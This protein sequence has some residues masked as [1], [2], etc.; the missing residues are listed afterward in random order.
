MCGRYTLFTPQEAIAE[1]VGAVR[2]APAPA[3]WD[4]PRYNIA[5]TQPVPIVRLSREGEL[6]LEWV[7]WGLVPFFR[8]SIKDGPLLINARAET[9]ATTAAFREA[10]AHRRCLVPANGFFE[11]KAAATKPPARSPRPKKQ[12]YFIH[13]VREELVL[14]AGLWER[15]RPPPTSA[16]PESPADAEPPLQSCAIITTAANAA[17]APLHDRMP[18]VLTVDAARD[19]LNPNA[20]PDVLSSLLA[21]APKDL[22]AVH[23][24]STEVNRAQQEG[25]QLIEPVTPPADHASQLD[26]F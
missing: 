17:V 15:W 3:P 13:P 6:I 25:P 26:L 8:K 18:A 20:H 7:R 24:V 22:M 23:P 19:W 16:H 21:P 10:F 2:I 5:P 12:P 14:F 4:L 11:W 9:V 1:L